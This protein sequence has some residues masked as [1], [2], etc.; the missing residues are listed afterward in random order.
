MLRANRHEHLE[1]GV[2]SE[3]IL[4]RAKNFSLQ[5]KS[6]FAITVVGRHFSKIPRQT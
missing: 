1:I 5:R 3:F 4:T 2:G 6:K